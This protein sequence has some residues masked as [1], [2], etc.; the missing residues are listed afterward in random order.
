MVKNPIF[1]V[2]GTLKALKLNR[3]LLERVKGG[4][5]RNVFLGKKF[6]VKIDLDKFAELDKYDKNSSW[7]KRQSLIEYI[8]FQGI[9][10]QD[11]KYFVPILDCGL[12]DGYFYVVQPRVKLLASPKAYEKK[13]NSTLDKYEQYET[14]I[15]EKYKVHDHNWFSNETWNNELKC[16]QVLDYG[17]SLKLNRVKNLKSL[18]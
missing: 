10:K 6:V 13:Q 1:K 3:E 17:S 5:Q 2:T 9:D 12:F 4:C 16:W 15:E 14:V 8:T 18:I 7:S 11:L